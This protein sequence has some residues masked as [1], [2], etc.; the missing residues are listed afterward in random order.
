MSTSDLATPERSASTNPATKDDEHLLT[1]AEYSSYQQGTA[2]LT[3]RCLDY[4][5]TVSIETQVRCNA[6]CSFCPYPESPR[7]GDEMSTP[8][9]EKIIDDLS[10]MP[11]NHKFQMTLSRINEPLLDHRLETFHRRIAD[12]LPGAVVSFWSNGTMLREGAFEWMAGHQGASL[13]I[14]LNAVNEADHVRLMGFGL[15]RVLINLDRVHQLKDKG[16]FPVEVKLRAP[17][18]SEQ[19]AR[20]MKDF[21][22]QRWPL[23]SL[24]LRPFFEWVGGSSKGG[25][26]RDETTARRA[27]TAA[28]LNFS[29][30][31]W[32]DLHVLAS[33]YATKCCIDE[34][35][36]VGEDRYDLSKHHA[37]DV[38]GHSRWLRDELPD[39]SGVSGCG[40]CR[41][42]G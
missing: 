20:Q 19:Q 24:G 14:S 25:H 2:A 37:L 42:L 12:K 34:T 32:F 3:N 30:A 11:P 33:G 38:Y 29:C 26:E 22:T 6:K 15:D 9:F 21:C 17:Y 13:F 18:E 1:Q 28:A 31:Q 40:G 5:R 10:I 23:F 7:K 41:H 8:L 36:F 35:G 16:E 4:P 27:E 39:R